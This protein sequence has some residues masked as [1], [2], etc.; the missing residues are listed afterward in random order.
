MTK[1]DECVLEG[2][3]GKERKKR[4]ACIRVIFVGGLQSLRKIL[5]LKAKGL[6]GQ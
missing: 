3:R 1:A 2:G 6:R 5:S 4:G